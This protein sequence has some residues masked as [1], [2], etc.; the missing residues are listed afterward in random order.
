MKQT[1]KDLEQ[2]VVRLRTQL[3]EA[4]DNAETYRS[5]RLKLVDAVNACES[6][7]K[8]LRTLSYLGGDAI[9]NTVSLHANYETN[10]AYN[11]FVS[12]T[13]V[14]DKRLTDTKDDLQEVEIYTR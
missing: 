14:V 10:D 6:T 4:R 8:Q 5:D 11:L 3:I 7:F 13:D 2:L 9:F 1:K 12:I